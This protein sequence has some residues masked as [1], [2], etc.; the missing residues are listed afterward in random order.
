VWNFLSG[1]GREL[2]H[3][4]ECILWWVF[5]NT[6]TLS[7]FCCLLL[8]LILLACLCSQKLLSAMSVVD[9]FAIMDKE[10]EQELKWV[11]QNI[12]GNDFGVVTM[13]GYLVDSARSRLWIYDGFYSC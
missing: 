12:L 13:L 4:F 10:R 7:C 8:Y 5:A 11:A 1:I 6:V 3:S 9:L 2:S